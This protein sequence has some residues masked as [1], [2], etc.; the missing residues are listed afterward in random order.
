MF[1]WFP[2]TLYVL[3][4]FEQLFNTT[5]VV[6]VLTGVGDPTGFTTLND[7]HLTILPQSQSVDDELLSSSFEQAIVNNTIALNNSF[8]ILIR[9]KVN[10]KS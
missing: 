1:V 2:F 10:K 6:N 8:F 5:N 9:F 7:E 3:S 4:I